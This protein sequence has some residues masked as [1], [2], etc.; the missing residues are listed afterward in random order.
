MCLTMSEWRLPR[1]RVRPDGRISWPTVVQYR[2]SAGMSTL[3]PAEGDYVTIV[4]DRAAYD[5]L[6]RRGYLLHPRHT[7]TESIATDNRGAPGA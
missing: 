7:G 4:I 2:T 5:E 6:W 1:T 3:P